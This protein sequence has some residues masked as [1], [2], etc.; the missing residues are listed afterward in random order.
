[1]CPQLDEVRF[2]LER[3]EA[4]LGDA[5]EH[6]G[7]ISQ[8]IDVVGLCRRGKQVLRDLDLVVKFYCRANDVRV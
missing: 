6:L 7:Y 1:M 5:L 2:V 3:L 8:V 4:G